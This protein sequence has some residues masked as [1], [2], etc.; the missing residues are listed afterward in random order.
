MRIRWTPAAAEDLQHIN[1]YL[2]DHHPH[3]RQATIRKIYDAL[4]SLK[5]WPH[6]GRAGREEGTRELC[7]HRCSTSPSIV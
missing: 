2:A 7:S 5:D 6:L 1:D 4:Q 3:Y